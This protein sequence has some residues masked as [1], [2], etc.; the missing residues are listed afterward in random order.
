MIEH[1][2]SCLEK[3]PYL[4]RIAGWLISALGIIWIFSQVGCMPVT[5]KGIR[6]ELGPFHGRLDAQYRQ[7]AEFKAELQGEV[8]KLWASLDEVANNQKT[9]AE[10]AAATND[11]LVQLERA[12]KITHRDLGLAR[13]A[14]DH[15]KKQMA[16]AEAN[17]REYAEGLSE[18][19]NLHSDQARDGLTSHDENVRNGIGFVRKDIVDLGDDTER[20]VERV[21]EDI[22]VNVRDLREDHKKISDAVVEE[23]KKALQDIKQL[24]NV[25]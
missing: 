22:V 2:S 12:S 9:I 4:V 19:M 3:R 18:Q 7:T 21:R 11:S 10:W 5:Q 1:I 24:L 15:M 14:I 8:A 17:R 25:P 13:S 16:A 23:R 6:H 20:V